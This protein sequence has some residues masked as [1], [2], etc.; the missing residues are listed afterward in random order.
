MSAGSEYAW[1]ALDN[2]FYALVSPTSKEVIPFPFKVK[3]LNNQPA[4]INYRNNMVC[5]VGNNV[6]FEGDGVDF[7]NIRDDS[8]TEDYCIELFEKQ[9]LSQPEVVPATKR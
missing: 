2:Q 5:S 9:F 6:L 7:R 8:K 4:R 1:T 3:S